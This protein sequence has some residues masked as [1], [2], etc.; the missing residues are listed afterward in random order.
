MEDRV[1]VGFVKLGN[2]G[3]SMMLDLALDE[4]AE[5]EDVEFR[6]VTSGP[7]MTKKD[8]QEVA[9]KALDIDS[10]L[11]I[12]ASPNPGTPG[13]E[14]AREIL[15]DSDV[16]C[17]IIGDAPGTKISDDLEEEGFGYIF[18]MADAMI[19]ARREFL[20]PEEMALFNSDVVKVLAV[21]GALRAAQDEID[22]VISKVKEGETYLPQTIIDSD[23]AVEAAGF[24]NPY[25]RNK[26]TAAFEI[27]AKVADLTVKGCFRVQD[28]DKYLPIVGSAH[29]MMRMAAKLCD[30]AREIE[31]GNNSVLRRPHADDGSTL[32]KREF[33]ET[34]K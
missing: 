12:I 19:G 13:P 18:V 31:K 22:E 29:E 16:P 3:T 25:A 8:C 20:D 23:V 6:N 9:K 1:T 28:S 30:E 11:I 27:A 24:D 10:D 17:I 33:M 5:R 21:T 7:R 4:R 14:A 2:I 15:K 26:A 34:P 32:S